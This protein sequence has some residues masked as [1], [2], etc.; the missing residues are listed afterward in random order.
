VNFSTPSKVYSVIDN[1]RQASLLRAPNRVLINEMMN[2]L[3]PYSKQEEDEN[4]ILVNV[5]WKEGTN[6]LHQARRQFDQA[7][8][9]T[10]NYF[11]VALDSGPAKRDEWGR[12]I[13]RLINKPLKRH[14]VIAPRLLHTLR[15]KFASVVLHGP[16]SQ[17][18]DDRYEVTPTFIG[19]DDLF[20]PTD[21]LLTYEN[22]YY[23]SVRRGMKP[24][25]LYR[26]TFFC[27][28][29]VDPGWDL[30]L[31]QKIL[32]SYKDL[33]QNPQN[34]N[35][36]DNL[37][38]M[39]ELYK[40]NLTYFDG[41]SAPTIWFYEFFYQTDK[42][43]G[44]HRVMMLAEDYLPEGTKDAARK[45][46]YKS[47]TRFC[48]TLS[49]VLHTQFGD[50]N[51]VPPFKYH[52]IRG[53]GN[54]LYDVISM[55]NRVRCQLTQH[56]FEQMMMLFNVADPNDRSRIDRLLLLN[57]GI[58]PEGTTIVPSAQRHTIDS[59]LVQG[60]MN[61]YHQL[62]SNSTASYNEDLSR[63][64][65]EPETATAVMARMNAI[66][67]L[68]STMVQLSYAQETFSWREI[69][70]RFCIEHSPESMVQKFQE[71]CDREG[72]PRKYLDVNRWEVNPEQVLGDG[73][74]QLAV[75]EAT[76]LLGVGPQLDPEPQR[77][78]R[79]KYIAAVT[80]NDALAKELVPDD[81]KGRM[82]MSKHDATQSFG[83]LMQGIPI[84]PISGFNHPDQIETVLSLMAQVIQRINSSD[85]MGTPQDLIGLQ[86]AAKYVEDHIQ[87]LA[88]DKN[89]KQRVASYTNT[90]RRLMNFAKAFAQRQQQAQK[91]A[92]QQ[93]QQ[94][95]D[96]EALAKAQSD[97]L[98]TKV[99]I[100]G[101][102]A[103]DRQKLQHK[104][105][106][107]E[108]EQH[109]K[110][111]QLAGDTARQSAKTHADIYNQSM[112]AGADAHARR[113]AFDDD[114]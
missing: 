96:P 103:A 74:P 46:I 108:A 101:K 37:E 113:M 82:N 40:Q 6:A 110:N 51:N 76:Q 23:F 73:N 93:Q 100:A 62:V 54:M 30:K 9:R 27:G 107:F 53:V 35:W 58:M 72:I 63:K 81:P 16:G 114:E 20:I 95:H 12:T 105:Q 10:G 34:W 106:S 36:A 24:G 77:I 41:D 67:A 1:M 52:A 84:K 32:D 69:A 70:R 99:K 29:N 3:P 28:K 7:H 61:D 25:E 59:N 13:T 102:T 42:N 56:V 39:S 38:K 65:G 8:L 97:M 2:G 48:D 71:E 43:G 4:H 18:W 47:K 91:K 15:S 14:P 89:E 80:R 85:K 44:W 33:N 57:Q 26:K 17:I 5:N 60:L 86:T 94:A 21:T 45:F 87:I 98:L 104:Q 112:K 49:E 11:T 78:V 111:L 109:R 75:A 66:N 83:A 90:L 79:R 92:M 50:G 64:E 55:L 22:L 88:Q 68:T 19:I 31:V